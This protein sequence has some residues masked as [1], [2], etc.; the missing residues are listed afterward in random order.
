VIYNQ[1][2][3]G[4]HAFSVTAALLWNALPD[5]IKASSNVDTF[6]SRIKTFLFNPLTT[7][8][9]S[10]LYTCVPEANFEI[11]QKH[12]RQEPVYLVFP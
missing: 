11:M 12:E 8:A 3:Y 2:L 4:Y 5:S 10:H 1:K 6:K 9:R 7:G